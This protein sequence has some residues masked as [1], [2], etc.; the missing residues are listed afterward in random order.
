MSNHTRRIVFIGL[1]ESG[2]TSFIAAL[3]YSLMQ[4]DADSKFAFVRMPDNA[5]YLERI[6][7]NWMAFEPMIHTKSDTYEPILMELRDLQSQTDFT[8]EFPDVS[9]EDFD[10]QWEA[11]EWKQ[12]YSESVASAD[13]ILLFVSPSV[14]EPLTIQERNRIA[15]V[16]TPKN[17]PDQAGDYEPSR[18][19]TGMKLV[20]LLQFIGEVI[21]K[22]RVVRICVV[23]SAWD[24]EMRVPRA[25]PITPRGW[26]SSKIPLLDQFL[27]CNSEW[28][29][30]EVFG[31]S[32]QGGDY[33]ADIP[34]LCALDRAID[35]IK[36]VSGGQPTHDIALPIHW[37]L[38]FTNRAT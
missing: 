9:G 2:K 31:V 14:V 25:T 21:P 19:P 7:A 6:A 36:V 15:G 23:I 27:R 24:L 18:A 3:Y 20:E 16:E 10:H 29:T 17:E 5:E 11:R 22:G 37:V 35:R 26:L 4:D 28:L 34:A 38:G 8:L 12:E 30:A 13:G 33:D 32:A 1:P